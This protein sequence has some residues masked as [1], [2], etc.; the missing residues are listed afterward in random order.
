MRRM[1]VLS[2]RRCRGALN[3]PPLLPLPVL[4][5]AEPPPLLAPDLVSP[6]LAG[7][8]ALTIPAA[9]AATKVPTAAAPVICRIP[10][11]CPAVAEEGAALDAPDSRGSPPDTAAMLPGAY[12]MGVSV[13]AL[14]V[15]RPGVCGE[16]DA[17]VTCCNITSGEA[18]F[19]A[20]YARS[21]FLSGEAAFVASRCCAQASRAWPSPWSLV[22]PTGRLRFQGL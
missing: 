19:P 6:E 16:A 10:V 17:V 14:A 4:A 13:S 5:C 22:S 18:A 7:R 9:A 21:R 8:R 11:Q 1:G 3:P 20:A 12:P 2:L 15:V